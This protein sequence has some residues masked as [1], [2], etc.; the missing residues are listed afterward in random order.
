MKLSRFSDIRLVK[1]KKVSASACS[2][3]WSRREPLYF[4]HVATFHA[5]TPSLT[6]PLAVGVRSKGV[7]DRPDD[8]IHALDVRYPR[9]QFGVDKENPFHHLPVRF[10]STGHHLVFI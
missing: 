1:Q 3:P 2:G 7:V 9:V 6:F 5:D 8:L 4:L 10:T